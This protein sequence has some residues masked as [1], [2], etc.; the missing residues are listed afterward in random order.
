MNLQ[1]EDIEIGDEINNPLRRRTVSYKTALTPPKT[2]SFILPP[3][4]ST[5]P[6]TSPPPPPPSTS[7]NP[8][9]KIDNNSLPQLRKIIS[10]IRI[11]KENSAKF[12]SSDKNENSPIIKTIAYDNKLL[13]LTDD[14]LLLYG[15]M[16]NK[17]KLVDNILRILLP[18]V[19]S[20]YIGVLL[21]VY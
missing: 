21:N 12:V 5:S 17:I 4:P 8:N 11:K 3:P 1:K 9:Q 2:T 15:F 7:T 16:T 10:E 20:I 13:D 18:C 19:F 14:E 6:P